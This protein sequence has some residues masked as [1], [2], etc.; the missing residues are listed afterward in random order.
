[1]E[2]ARWLLDEFPLEEAR[3]VL[4]LGCGVGALLPHL[5]KVAPRAR[6]VGLD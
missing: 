3:R 1:V 6:I 2:L 4:D 5:H